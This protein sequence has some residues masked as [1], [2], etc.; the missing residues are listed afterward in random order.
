MIEELYVEMLRKARVIDVGERRI[1]RT[2]REYR[3]R[4]RFVIYLPV[5]RNDVWRILW[6]KRILVKVFL[7]LPEEAIKESSEGNRGGD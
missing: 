7:E 2:V 6:E 3:G 4:S 1:S 5:T